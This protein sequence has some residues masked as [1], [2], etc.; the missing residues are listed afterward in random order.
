MYMM[1]HHPYLLL[2]IIIL[3][4]SALEVFLAR[5]SWFAGSVIPIVLLLQPITLFWMSSEASRAVF[6]SPSGLLLLFLPFVVTVVVL[7]ICRILVKKGLLKKK[8]PKAQN[9]KDHFEGYH[10]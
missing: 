6:S 9:K 5:R 3:I 8:A 7:F 10:L 1:L 2:A 4:L